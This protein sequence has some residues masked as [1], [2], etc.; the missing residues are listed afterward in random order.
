MQS[1][2]AIEVTGPFRF[3]NAITGV[4]E[5]FNLLSQQTQAIS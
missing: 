1:M 2:A 4:G 5:A 3:Y